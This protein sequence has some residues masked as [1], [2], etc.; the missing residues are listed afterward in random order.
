MHA[1]WALVGSGP[2]EPGFH[3]QAAGPRRP[4]LPRLGRPGGGE[5]GAGRAGDPRRRS[6]HWPRDPSPDVRLQVAIAA[7]KLE[8]VDPLA[9]LL[10]VQSP[11]VAIRLIPQIVWQNLH[12][13]LEDRQVEIRPAVARR[14]EGGRLASSPLVA[15]R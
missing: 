1:L 6:S 4:D 12:P 14:V 8:G 9:V 11:A 5:H 3:A 10:D 15:A 7:R 2:L 13:L